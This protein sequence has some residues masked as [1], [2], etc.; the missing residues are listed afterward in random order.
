MIAAN[1]E[2]R[3]TAIGYARVSTKDQ[4]ER[5][6]SLDA[7]AEKI[8]A[9]VTLHDLELVEIIRNDGYSAKSLDRPGRAW[10]GCWT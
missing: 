5:G 3:R 4:A 9:Y 2:T 7:Q 1:T 8:R 10:G 6:V